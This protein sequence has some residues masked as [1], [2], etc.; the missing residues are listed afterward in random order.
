M[1]ELIDI[2]IPGQQKS[3]SLKDIT[4]IGRA[5]TTDIKLDDPKVSRHHARICKSDTGYF[6]EDLGS[7]NGVFIDNEL[8][9]SSRSLSNGNKVCIGSYTLIF[10]DTEPHNTTSTA[11]NNVSEFTQIIRA[12][13]DQ[14]KSGK[15]EE[16]IFREAVNNA[17]LEQ[18][19]RRLTIF[20]DITE[21]IS[22]IFNIDALLDE[23]IQIIF[24]VFPHAGRC[25]V[26]LQDSEE[27]PLS[28]R[29]LQTRDTSLPEGSNILSQTLAQRAI[30]EQKALLI[31]DTQTDARVSTSIKIIGARSILCAPLICPQKTIGILQIESKSKDYEFSEADLDL[32]TGI[33]S[34]VALLIYNAELLDDLKKTKERVESENRNLKRQQKVQSSFNSIV[35]N[36][37]KLKE[38][39]ELVR[40]VSNAPYS[41]LITGESGS[42]K[43]LI[44]K[45]IHYNSRRA[46]QPFVVL[47]CAAIPKDLLESELFGHEK[48]SFTGATETRQGLFEVANNGTV[49]L[50]E[51]GDMNPHTQAK[52]LRVL[53]EKEFQRVGGTKVIR[54]NVRVL[55][56]TNKDLKTA[57]SNG[58]F[59]EDL[60]YRLNVV[61]IHIPPLR[62]RKE[63]IPL[64]IEHFLTLSC[65]DVGKGISGFTAEAL[66]FLVNYK[67]P[68]NVRE[69]KNVIERIVT[70]AHDDSAIGIE[71]LPPEIYNKSVLQ[72]QKYKTSGNLYEAQKQLEIEMLVDAL[73]TTKGNK[74]KAAELLGLSRKVLYEKIDAHK[75]QFE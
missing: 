38:I 28:I 23:I 11:E 13:R 51:I 8:I 30:K 6:I 20:H 39:L 63:D 68:G 50:D 19:Q 75:I 34:Q 69:L 26:A 66:T 35:G 10:K 3:Y 7:L 15:A 52:L 57:I 40:K 12:T 36:S 27:T 16:T 55:A 43:E 54:V 25:F 73:K 1:A 74:S 59:R 46:G 24:T 56:A 42:G 5:S 17:E 64:L 18:L 31:M 60:F 62:E 67:W 47:N 41:V 49:F 22:D 37:S 2:T 45:A 48:G 72:V 53:Q 21:A 14:L 65:A 4:V 32:F 29:T 61:P 33:A 58:G 44:A 70:L 71:M 9:I